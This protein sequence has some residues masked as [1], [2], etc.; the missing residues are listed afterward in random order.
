MI[1]NYYDSLKYVQKKLI[2]YTTQIYK[3]YGNELLLRLEEYNLLSNENNCIESSTAIGFIMEEFIT[4]KLSIYTNKHDGQNEIRLHKLNNTS[5]QTSSYDCYVEYNNIFIM[6][7]I[8]SQK[9][10]SNNNAIS[11]INKL[12]NDYVLTNPKREKAF[13]IL[14]TDYRFGKSL[15]DLQRKIIIEKIESFYLEEIDFSSGHK[16]DNRNWSEEFNHNS[17]RLQVPNS[18]RNVHTLIKDY[19]SYT[20]TFNMIKHIY[21]YNAA[22]DKRR[23]NIKNI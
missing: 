3:V 12:Y 7:N 5:T 8:K 22:L 17:G 14:K 11:A 18:F 19:V 16:Q 1:N 10:G 21:E 20:N 23:K 2:E 6:I 4:S 13:L 15:K 9:K